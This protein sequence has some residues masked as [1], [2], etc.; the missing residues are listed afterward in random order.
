MIKVKNMVATRTGNPVT[1][2]F[3]IENNGVETFQSYETTIAIRQANGVVVLDDRAF[4]YSRITSKYLREFLYGDGRKEVE[5][6]VKNNDL[7]YVYSNL[8]P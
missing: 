8:N 7:K 4:D 3:I 5:R 2:Q 1:N 6:S